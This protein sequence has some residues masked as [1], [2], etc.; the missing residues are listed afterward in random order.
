MGRKHRWRRE[1]RSMDQVGSEIKIVKMEE[2]L[3]G[4]DKYGGWGG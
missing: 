3:V 1:I 2:E 4:V